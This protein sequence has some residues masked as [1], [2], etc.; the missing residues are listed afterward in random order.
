[1]RTQHLGDGQ[2]QVSCRRPLRELS[3]KLEADDPWDQHRDWL[4]K[5]GCFCL[6]AADTPTHDTN[7]IDHRRVGVG[8]NTGVWIGGQLAVDLA[9]EDHSSQMLDVDLVHD[10]GARRNY[11]EI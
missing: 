4:A 9:C 8:A 5:H 7:A 11:L 10:A 3:G 6:N 1:M 2:H